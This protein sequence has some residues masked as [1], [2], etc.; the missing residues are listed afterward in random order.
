MMTKTLLH[1]VIIYII[2]V[3]EV[4]FVGTILAFSV[5]RGEKERDNIVSS[6]MLKTRHV[7]IIVAG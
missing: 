1:R 5:G 6:L 2:W 3:R 7:F 4:G